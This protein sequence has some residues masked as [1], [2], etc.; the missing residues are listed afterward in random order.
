MSGRCFE[1]GWPAHEDHHVI[2]RSLGGTKTVPLCRACHGIVHDHERV[3]LKSL[4]ENALAAQKAQ[5]VRLGKKR[6][7]PDWILERVVRERD[8]GST[9]QKIAD[10]LNREGVPLVAGGKRWYTSTCQAVYRAARLDREADAARAR[11]EADRAWAE[12]A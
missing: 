3:V 4:S 1:C 8:A 10:G 12:A 9:W 7:T 11:Y 2:P 6:T 5:G